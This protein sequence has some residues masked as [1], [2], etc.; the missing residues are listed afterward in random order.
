M[1]AIF[2]VL[3]SRALVSPILPTRIISVCCWAILVRVACCS[4]LPLDRSEEKIR[5]MTIRAITPTRT[6]IIFE[7]VELV[8]ILKGLFGVFVAGLVIKS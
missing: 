4:L 7:L 6:T 5:A 3:G 1:V 2:F 8:L